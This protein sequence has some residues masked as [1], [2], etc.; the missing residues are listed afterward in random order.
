MEWQQKYDWGSY[1]QDPGR[2]NEGGL[3]FGGILGSEISE[4]LAGKR[5]FS[6]RF[7]PCR[8]SGRPSRARR[9]PGS[10]CCRL[11]RPLAPSLRHPEAGT[12]VRSGRN[13]PLRPS[14]S[15][16][17]I[18]SLTGSAHFPSADPDARPSPAQPCSFV[19]QRSLPL[20]SPRE[21]GPALRRPAQLTGPMPS[22]SV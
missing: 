13:P 16:P 17:F 19:A 5:D 10:A 6:P 15:S 14:S 2:K 3:S 18:S 21:F 8:L 22:Q 1:K 11:S 7:R 20:P 12:A 9:S 4:T